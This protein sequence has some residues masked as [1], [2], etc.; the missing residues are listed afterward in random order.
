MGNNRI[1]LSHLWRMHTMLRKL[2]V[3]TFLTLFANTSYGSPV[4]PMQAGEIWEYTAEPTDGSASWKEL[5]EFGEPV[6]LDSKLY[7]PVVDRQHR[8]F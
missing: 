2:F 5:R 4:W 3:V 8:V 7:F 6:T 1:R